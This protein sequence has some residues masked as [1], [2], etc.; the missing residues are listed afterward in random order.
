MIQ[1]YVLYFQNKNIEVVYFKD[2]DVYFPT[3]THVSNYTIGLVLSGT[4]LMQKDN[5]SMTFNKGD[6][7]IIYPNIP[8][9]IHGYNSSIISICINKDFLEHCELKEMLKEVH[10]VSNFLIERELIAEEHTDCPGQ[11][12]L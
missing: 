2:T 9:N 10:K 6:F 5:K 1:P 3:H 12:L 8:H 7:F 11:A 4:V